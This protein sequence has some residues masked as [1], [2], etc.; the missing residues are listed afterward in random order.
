MVGVHA[1]LVLCLC[2][3]GEWWR[4]E[5][6]LDSENGGSTLSGVCGGTTPPGAAGWEVTRDYGG[7][8]LSAAVEFKDFGWNCDS[9]FL[10]FF[11]QYS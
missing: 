8:G 6:I 7:Q 10:C 5:S 3:G 11:N 9:S 2:D 1:L 4:S